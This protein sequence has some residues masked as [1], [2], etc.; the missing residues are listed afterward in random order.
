MG[1]SKN[2]VENLKKPCGKF[3]FLCRKLEKSDIKLRISS[4][5]SKSIDGVFNFPDGLLNIF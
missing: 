2:H 3:N 5:K 1:K 4:R